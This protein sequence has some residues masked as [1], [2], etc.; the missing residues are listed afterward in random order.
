MASS[1]CVGSSRE[2]MIVH[3]LTYFAFISYKYKMGIDPFTK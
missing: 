3:L 1:K 2:G